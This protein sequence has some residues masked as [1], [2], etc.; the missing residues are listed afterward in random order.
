[1]TAAVAT[2]QLE[3][4]SD[5]PIQRYARV[6]ALLILLSAVFGGLGESYIPS[7]LIVSGDAAATVSHITSSPMLFRLGF[8]AYLVEAVCDVALA[9]LFYV[10]LRPAGQYLALFT[11]FLG[12]ISTTLYA[13]AEACYF[14]PSVLLGGADYLKPFSPDQL[15]ALSLLSLKLFGTIAGLFLGFYG[16]ATVVR[17]YLM[18]RS[19]YLPRTIGVLFVIAGAAF[20]ADSLAVVLAPRFVSGFLLMPMGVAGISLMLWLFIKGVDAEG[21]RAAH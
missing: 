1:M 21:W 16:L 17:G 8:A 12:L 9:L 19:G 7:K 13:V 14:A 4:A 11:A 6:M 18:Y 10:V 2:N 20:I 15:N 5:A 3:S